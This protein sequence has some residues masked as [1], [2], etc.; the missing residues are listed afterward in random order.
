MI[1][2]ETIKSWFSD[3]RAIMKD[4]ILEWKNPES[5][6]YYVRYVFDQNHIYITGDMGSAIFSFS[7]MA[8]PYISNYDLWYFHS[9]LVAYSDEKF[10]FNQEKAKK[11]FYENFEGEIPKD[12]LYGIENSNSIQEWEHFLHTHEMEFLKFDNDYWD[13]AYNIGNEI[14]V[15]V[16]AY[17]IGLEMAVEQLKKSG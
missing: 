8:T 9:K 14:P 10:E 7:E 15:R 4:N 5:I 17:K 3:H 2:D 12:I 6:I 1:T 11:Y 13:W 16:R